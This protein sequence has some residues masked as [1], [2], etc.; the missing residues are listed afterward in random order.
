MCNII[1]TQS[2]FGYIINEILK[3]KNNDYYVYNNMKDQYIKYCKNLQN[4]CKFLNITK[5][6]I[7]IIIDYNY[8]TL[9]NVLS[10]HFNYTHS[11]RY[12]HEL[13]ILIDKTYNQTSLTT[14]HTNLLLKMYAY[15]YSSSNQH[16]YLYNIYDI[17]LQIFNETKD[18]ISYRS[19]LS[20]LHKTQNYDVMTIFIKK[21]FNYIKY[22]INNEKLLEYTLPSIIIICSKNYDNK[23]T[24]ELT[25]LFLNEISIYNA[26]CIKKYLV[27]QKPNSK[28]RSLYDNDGN[29][30]CLICL[31]QYDNK[32]VILC[33]NCNK[34]IYHYICFTKLHNKICPYCKKQ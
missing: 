5:N 14:I 22:C 6:N 8:L 1:D 18:L 34:Y 21:N 17:Q 33:L 31:E 27:S 13:H 25:E 20:I 12:I 28:S 30:I 15:K 11:I 4:T 9:L 32:N 16:N 26:K 19:I 2:D 7:D 3:N 10:F 29:T 24:E 23:L